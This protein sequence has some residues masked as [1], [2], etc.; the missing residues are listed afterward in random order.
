MVSNN[1]SNDPAAFIEAESII[2]NFNF[3]LSS[4]KIY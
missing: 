3:H 4:E 2:N 1:L